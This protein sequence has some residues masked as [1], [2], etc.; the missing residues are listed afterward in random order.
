MKVLSCWKIHLTT[1][2]GSL[3][4][5]CH[6]ELVSRRT[7]NGEVGTSSSQVRIKD[8]HRVKPK[9]RARRVKGQKEKAAEGHKRRCS[10][11]RKT[12]HDR[13]SCPKLV[14]GSSSSDAEVGAAV[15]ENLQPS[16]STQDREPTMTESFLQEFDFI[17]GPG[18]EYLLT[19]ICVFLET[20]WNR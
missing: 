6:Q 13:R 8:P 10:E 7:P 19:P 15:D 2:V 11:C 14:S 1:F 5:C 20:L 16:Q 17:Y 3:Q 9:G 12:D 18:F 4:G